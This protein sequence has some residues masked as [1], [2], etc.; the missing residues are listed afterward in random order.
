MKIWH[1]IL[2]FLLFLNIEVCADE[3]SLDEFEQEYS[4]YEV[5]DPISGYNKIMTNFNIALY[6]YGFRPILKGYNAITPEFFRT[7]VRNFFDNLLAPLR[8]IGNVFQFKFN[9]AGDEFKRF[10]ANTILGFGGVRDVASV[11]GIQKHHADVGAI[12][13]HWGV[14]SGFHIVLPVLGPSNLRDVLALPVDWFLQ[15]TAYINPTWLEIVVSAYGFGN[16]LSF[17]LDELD[18]I[19]YN[20]PNVYP[21]LRDAYEQRRIELSK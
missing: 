21:F 18:E 1:L 13:A 16:E 14:G 11:M 5:N 3:V 7:G 20:T 4:S 19:Y 17:R 15:P 10:L 6:D 2:V 9:E 12:L 8:F